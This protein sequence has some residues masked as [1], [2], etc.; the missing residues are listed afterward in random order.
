MC[1]F[2]S[3]VVLAV[4]EFPIRWAA[5][6]PNINH[7]SHED[8]INALGLRD[9]GLGRFYRPECLPPFDTVTLEYTAI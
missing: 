5:P 6:D 7:H 1:K 2:F 4:G 3:C 8:V 9:D